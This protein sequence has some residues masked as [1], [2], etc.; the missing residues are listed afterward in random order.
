MSYSNQQIQT[1]PGYHKYVCCCKEFLSFTETYKNIYSQKDKM[2][3]I[4][5]K[6]IQW[7]GR[8]EMS[9]YRDEIITF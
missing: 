3:R 5:F 1:H 8:G 6:V 9:G 2:V 4:R 7:W